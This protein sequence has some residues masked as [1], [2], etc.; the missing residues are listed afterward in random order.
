[1]SATPTTEGTP[2]AT[3]AHIT[4]IVDRSGSMSEMAQEAEAGIKKFI[5]EQAALDGVKVKVCLDQFDDVYEHV[6]GPVKA[7]DAPAY[8]LKPRSMTALYDAIG[9]GIEDTQAVIDATPE[10]KRPDKVVVVIVTDGAENSSQEHT[11]ES[12][13]K[14]VEARKAAGWVFIFLAGQLEA[15]K[16]GR[17]V[18]LTTTEYNPKVRGQ[19]QNAYMT[20]SGLTTRHLTGRFQATAD[21]ADEPSVSK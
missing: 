3:R 12:V 10:G 13:S 6:F 18:G 20:A 15:A 19:T 1:M 17:K 2:M 14:L 16:L 9:K 11:F 4:L 7:A 8:R 5:T 21:E